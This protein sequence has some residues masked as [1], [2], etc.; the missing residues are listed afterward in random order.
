[1]TEIYS[2]TVPEASVQNLGG[3]GLVPSWSC[4]GESISGLSQLLVAAGNP[5][6]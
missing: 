2:L 6:C 5:W 1:M 4:A 3:G